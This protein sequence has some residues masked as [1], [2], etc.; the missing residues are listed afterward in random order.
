LKQV[1]V[2]EGAPVLCGV[3][4]AAHAVNQAAHAVVG[5]AEFPRPEMVTEM[6]GPAAANPVVSVTPANPVSPAALLDTLPLLPRRR[7][8]IAQPEA[9]RDSAERASVV[10]SSAGDAGVTGADPGQAVIPARPDLNVLAQVL[11]GLR[12]MA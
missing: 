9:R 11:E 4:A 1:K 12:R 8:V 3:S 5:A 6:T 2:V 7:R 10:G